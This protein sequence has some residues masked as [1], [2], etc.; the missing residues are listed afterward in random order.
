MREGSLP[1]SCFQTVRNI[2]TGFSSPLTLLFSEPAKSTRF[3]FPVKAANVTQPGT[4]HGSN[5]GH[6]LLLYVIDHSSLNG[7][8][9][10]R[11]GR[12]MIEVRGARRAVFGCTSNKRSITHQL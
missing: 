11:T 12:R 10:M 4:L 1:V 2:T 7:Q 3:I 6:T 5:D 9:G 8:N